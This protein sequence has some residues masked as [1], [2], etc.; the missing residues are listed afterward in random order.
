MKKCYLCHQVRELRH[1][2]IVPEF[3]YR[4]LYNDK[5]QLMAVSGLGK[6]GRTLLQNGIKQHLFCEECEQHFNE[7]FEKP[8][9]RWLDTKQLPNPWALGRGGPLDGGRLR[10]IQIVPS[11]CPVPCFGLFARDVQPRVARPPP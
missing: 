8:F 5:R 7:H 3:L 10:P 6:R 11:E 2:H 9:K 1:S 4:E